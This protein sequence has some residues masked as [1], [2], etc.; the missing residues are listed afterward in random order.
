MNDRTEETIPLADLTTHFAAVI[1][2]VSTTGR[3]VLV[4]REE[5]AAVVIMA[6]PHYRQA[7]R[8][9]LVFQAILAGEGDVRIGRIVSHDD[10]EV[11]LGALLAH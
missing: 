1:E 11:R 7:Q 5:D 9:H 10:V 4:L 8:E 3:P 6:V 2:R